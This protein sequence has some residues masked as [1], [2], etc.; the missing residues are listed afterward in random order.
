MFVNDLLRRK[1][2]FIWKNL[3]V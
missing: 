3:Y 1:L 2:H